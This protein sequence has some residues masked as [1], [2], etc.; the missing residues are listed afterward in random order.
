[1]KVVA[2][3]IASGVLAAGLALGFASAG[4]ADDDSSSDVSGGFAQSVEESEAVIIRVPVNAQGAEVTDDAEMVLHHG[5][6]LGTSGDL[7][8]AFTAG[9]SVAEQ[10]E[11]D[12]DSDS[13][14]SHRGYYGWNRWRY[15]G[16]YNNYYRGYSPVYYYGSNYW[17]YSY[18]YYRNYF[19]YRYYYYRRCW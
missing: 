18:S 4:F 8:A 10:P 7:T 6:D 12:L 19:G 15:N 2:R 17:N 11:V 3:V 14:T 9:Q 5:A 16:C 13:S 1:M